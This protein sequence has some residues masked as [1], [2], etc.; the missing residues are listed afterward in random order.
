MKNVLDRVLY[1]M[2][3][4]PIEPVFGTKIG[5]VKGISDV[6]AVGV[7]DV[8]SEDVMVCPA[9]GEMPIDGSCNCDHSSG[10]DEGTI[11]P[12]CNMMV[13]GGQ[14]GCTH[15]DVCPS[16]QMMPTQIDS[17]CGCGLNEAS[18]GMCRECGMT[19]G[20][21]QC[22][23]NEKEEKGPSKE[24]LKKIFKGDKTFDDK[25][26]TAKAMKGIDDPKAF[27][28]WATKKITGKYPRED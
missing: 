19:E 11:C 15:D 22:G 1:E 28:A 9:C 17:P 21:C 23:M 3:G 27:A 14:C 24:T 10:D 12:G 5:D 16:C 20:M 2:F 7:R 6:G 8:Q 13:V 26:D 4:D 18:E 25:V